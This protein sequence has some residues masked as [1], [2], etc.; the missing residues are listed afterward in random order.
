MDNLMYSHKEVPPFYEH[1]FP[2]GNHPPRAA[3]FRQ[4]PLPKNSYPLKNLQ[5]HGEWLFFH[6]A[7]LYEW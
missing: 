5:V 6:T 4:Y 7:L 3:A 1:S 2:S